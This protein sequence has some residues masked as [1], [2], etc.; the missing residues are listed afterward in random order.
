MRLLK[1]PAASFRLR[2]CGDGGQAADSRLRRARKAA[3]CFFVSMLIAATTVGGQQPTIVLGPFDLILD[4]YVRD[5]YVYYRALRLERRRL[6]EFV[7]QIAVAEV[8]NRTKNE[9]M[10]F[11]LNA[12]NALVLRTVIDH[13]PAPRRSTEYPQRSIRQ[14]PGA[15]ERLPHRV[16]GRTLTLDQIEQ[17]ILPKF[18]DPRL[19]FALGRG[20]VGGGRLRSEAFSADTIERQLT[21]VAGECVTRAECVHVDSATNRLMASAIF[22]WHEKE[23]V[24]A[25]ADKVDPLYASRSPIERAILAFVQ[26]KLLQTERDV[27]E[28]NTFQLA[29]KPFDWSL[30]DLTGRGDR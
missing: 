17:T 27:L 11:W 1:G 4:T 13:Y 3:H 18:G 14:T 15:F 25:Y 9:Q 16:A 23:F 28:K 6:D 2:R 21:E 12:Y 30:N 8:D 26:P 10:A 5:G 20:A 22:S 24:A 19:Y 29:Y 7:R